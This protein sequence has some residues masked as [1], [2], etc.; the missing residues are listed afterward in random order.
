VLCLSRRRTARHG[1][2][3]HRTDV[4]TRPDRVVEV[5]R[6]WKSNTVDGL[7][8]GRFQIAGSS[9]VSDSMKC[10]Q[11]QRESYI[12]QKEIAVHLYI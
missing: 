10:E 4:A 3:V 12:S 7:V 9:E 11:E 5:Q 2:H 1:V 6:V 8:V